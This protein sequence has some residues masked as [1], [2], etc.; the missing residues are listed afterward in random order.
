M[1]SLRNFCSG[2]SFLAVPPELAVLPDFAVT[3]N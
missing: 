3:S 1:K 2:Q